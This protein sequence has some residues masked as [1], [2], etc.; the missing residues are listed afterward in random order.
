MAKKELAYAGLN[1]HESK[2]YMATLELGET[3]I[4]RI[5]QKSG[6]QRTTTYRS[7]ES[8]KEMGLVS[9]IKKNKKTFFYAEDPRALERKMDERK[10]A[11]SKI[12]PELL[13]ITNLIDKKPIVRYFEGREGLEEVFKDVLNYPNQEV[14][15][16]FPQKMNY[17]HIKAEFFDDFYMPARIKRGIHVR[18]IIPDNEEMKPRTVNAQNDLRRIKIVSANKLHA[19][20]ETLIYG[21]GKIGIISH[22]E[23]IALL[24]ESKKMF[25]FHKNVFELVW[26][27]LPEIPRQ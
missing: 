5:A 11:V 24:I 22:E 17:P 4:A 16:W 27:S 19:D 8:L 21:N 10:L 20:V 26:D 14:L 13:S 7:I 15:A 2:V 9:T 12:I 23:S 1:E 18:S 25:E 6:I 3:T